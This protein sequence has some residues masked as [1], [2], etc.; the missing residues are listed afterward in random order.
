VIELEEYETTVVPHL[1]VAPR[2]RELLTRRLDRRI[3]LDWLADDQLRVTSTQWVGVVQHPQLGVRVRPKLAGTDLDVLTM[4]TVVDGGPTAKLNE[5]ERELRT[6]RDRPMLDLVCLLLCR[7]TS[8]VLAQGPLQDYRGTEDDLPVLR[9]SLLIHRQAVVHY[10]RVDR[11]ACRHDEHDAD[12]LDNRVLRLALGLARRLAV[13]TDVRRQATALYEEL[14]GLAPGP[15]PPVSELR[16][17]L[18]YDRRNDHYRAAHYWALALLEAHG[19][20]DPLALG[21]TPATVVLFDMN[22]LFEQFVDWLLMDVLRSSGVQVATQ[23]GDRSVLWK[24]GARWK[25]IRPDV[26]LRRGSRVLAVDAKYKRYDRAAPDL[27]DVYQLF[28][29]SQAYPG[30]G[31]TPLALL[32]HPE[33]VAGATAVTLEVRPAG[34]VLGRVLCLPVM[35]PL[36]LTEVRGGTSRQ[37]RDAFY[38]Q[39]TAG[40]LISQD[41]PV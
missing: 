12:V 27:A 40:A 36:L 2:T 20:D 9:G 4:L 38:E 26:L 15:V 22:R 8:A 7:A 3:G 25:S 13:A 10:G 11:L 33:E 24:D 30:F 29:Y 14:R 32:V 41:V 34:E 39:V 5:L 16:R 35:L 31:S 37:V 6:A 1:P 17:L 19:V 18:A 21:G 23:R 28:L